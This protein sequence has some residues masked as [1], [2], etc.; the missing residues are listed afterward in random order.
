[1]PDRRQHALT[2]LPLLLLWLFGQGAHDPL[3]HAGE[4]SHAGGGDHS[5]CS[6]FQGLH[7]IETAAVEPPAPLPLRIG[8]ACPA[9]TAA[10]RAARQRG[11]DSR[12]PP[13]AP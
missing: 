5:S 7:Q 12:A 2:L 8:Q 1:M 3:V 6:F 4:W 11:I 13:V 9:P 10:P